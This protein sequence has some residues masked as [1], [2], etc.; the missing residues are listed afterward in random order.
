M[1]KCVSRT[2]RTGTA[3]DNSYP[4]SC[5]SPDKISGHI[6]GSQIASMMRDP[7]MRSSA[8]V[9]VCLWVVKYSF[10]FVRA[11]WLLQLFETDTV[12]LFFLPK[13]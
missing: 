5:L 3:V 11:H 12:I 10:P 7:M 1:C 4:Y 8:S 2:L 6:Y 9:V 13:K